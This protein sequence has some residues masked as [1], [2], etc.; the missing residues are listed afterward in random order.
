[1]K[2]EGRFK[3][4]IDMQATCVVVAILEPRLRWFWRRSRETKYPHLRAAMVALADGYFKG[5][6]GTRGT[7]GRKQRKREAAKLAMRLVG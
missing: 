5:S 3:L 1:M 6:M 7:R 4:E 2:D